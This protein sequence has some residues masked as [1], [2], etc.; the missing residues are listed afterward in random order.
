[1]TDIVRISSWQYNLLAVGTWGSSRPPECI[2]PKCLEVTQVSRDAYR[3][4]FFPIRFL[5]FWDLSQPALVDQCR[6]S[7]GDESIT[8]RFTV[9]GL[10]SAHAMQS[11]TFL[12]QRVHYIGGGNAGIACPAYTHILAYAPTGKKKCGVER[13]ENA[14]LARTD[15]KGNVEAV[16]DILENELPRIFH[17]KVTISIHRIFD[18]RC[19]VAAIWDFE[20]VKHII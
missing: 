20:V 5:K 10:Q 4:F 6:S 18:K 2:L 16:F 17:L 14:Y 8:W 1:M 3:N 9:P 7:F 15:T 11:A 19:S 13:A 12:S